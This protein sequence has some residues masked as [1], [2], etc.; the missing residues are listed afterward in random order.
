MTALYITIAIVIALGL[1]YLLFQN[2]KKASLKKVE[3]YKN[4]GARIRFTHSAEK[5]LM[6]QLNTLTGSVDG[7]EIKIFELITGASNQSQFLHTFIQITPNPF[8]FQ[9]NISRKN[10]GGKSNFELGDPSIDD[11]FSFLSSNPDEFRKLITPAVTNKL[12]IATSNFGNGITCDSEKL[13]HYF[14]GGL[15]TEEQTAELEIILNIMQL[16]VKNKA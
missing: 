15:T 9:F 16:L 12:L 7:Y 3:W 11:H 8:N 5:Y 10:L 14:M 1:L 4:W 2:G 6:A 13:E